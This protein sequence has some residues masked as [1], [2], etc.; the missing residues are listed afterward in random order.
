MLIQSEFVS[1]KTLVAENFK[2]SKLWNKLMKSVANE[3][4]DNLS[5]VSEVQSETS[6]LFLAVLYSTTK[7]DYLKARNTLYTDTVW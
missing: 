5:E 4:Q 3:K 6:K 1:R 2:Q 7:L